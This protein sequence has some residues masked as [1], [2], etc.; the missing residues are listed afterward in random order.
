[1]E[2]RLAA[3]A[4]ASARIFRAGT[5]DETLK[6]ITEEARRIV[7]AHQCVTSLTDG[8]DWAQSVVAVSLSDKYAAWRNYEAK[9]DGA[10]IYSKV[11]RENRTMRLTQAELEAHPA[12]R[13]FGAEKDKHP[14]LRGWLAAP[15]VARDGT[16]LGLIQLSDKYDGEFDAA[17]E[18]AVVQLA[19]HAALA[20][21][22]LRLLAKAQAAER[23]FQE[24]AE[25]A[26]DWF[27]ETDAEH[28]FTYFG[29]TLGPLD[30]RLGL[31]RW[32]T[33][34]ADLAEAKW[35][36]HLA[37]LAARRAFR[38]FEYT[39]IDAAG[40]LH[41]LSVSGN[42]VFAAG[43]A[44]TGY[45]GTARDITGPREIE[46]KALAAADR[47]RQIV[48]TTNEGVWIV[49]ADVRTVFVNR[50]M[51]EMLGYAAEEIL[52]RQVY[53]FRP[54]EDRAN[55]EN[56]WAKRQQGVAEHREARFVRRDG[57][58]F[59]AQISAQP[60]TDSAGAFAGSLGMVTDISARKEAEAARMAS[61][62]RFRDFAE[63]GTDWLW[64]SDADH[65][66]T[67]MDGPPIRARDFA[68]G[69][70]RWEYGGVDPESPEWRRHRSDL[71]LHKPFRNFEYTV[72]AADGT[73][74]HFSVSGK[75]LF[76]RDGLFAGYRGAT[77]DSTAQYAA[78]TQARAS[79]KRF[80]DFA[81]VASDWMWETDSEHRFSYFSPSR[82][83]SQI[84]PSS[85]AL[86]RTRWQY[87]GADPAE[88]A[89][90][91]HLADLEARR[92]IQR[93]EYRYRRPGGATG[94][95]LVNGKP[96]F[97]EDG[98]FAGYRGT[99]T[100]VTA[101][102][103]AEA[104]AR[105]ANEQFR[106]VVETANEGMWITD[107]DGNI[108]F[109]NN[110][111]A[112]MLGYEREELVGRSI[113]DFVPADRVADVRRHWSERRASK[114]DRF[115]ARHRRKDGSEI[116][117]LISVA[118]RTDASGAFAGSITMFVDITD[119][120]RAEAAAAASEQR[121]KD[122]AEV[123]SD[124]LWETDADHR[125][126][127]I[128]GSAL[129]L[130]NRP[131]GRTR[132]DLAGATADDPP[133]RAHVADLDAHRAFRD[134]AFTV[135]GDGG[136]THHLVASGR[137]QFDG[138]GR[139]Q[140]YRGT[141]T[142]R[143]R[144]HEAEA[145]ALE[146]ERNFRRIV[147]TADEGIWMLDAARKTSYVNPRMAEM[148]GY[149]ADEMLG[150]F[151][152]EFLAPEDRAEA[153]AN[154]DKRRQNRV[155]KREWR[156]VRKDGTLV[157]TL[158]TSNTMDDQSGGAPG[159]LGMITDITELK[160]AEEA[161]LSAKR[162]MEALLASVSDG[163]VAIDNEW[164]FTYVNPAAERIL[165]A[166]AA[167]VIGRTSI[168]ALGIKS[169]NVFNACYAAAKRDGEP[170]SFTAYSEAFGRWLEVR[171]HPH[172]GGITLFF[173]DVTA[174]RQAH[175]ALAETERNLR[176]ALENNESILGSVSDGFAAFDDQWRFTHM[177]AAAERIW[178]MAGKDLIGRS[179]FDVM[180]IDDANPFHAAYID[181][182]KSGAPTAF[183]AY[184]QILGKWIE[185]HGFPH[186]GG[187][188]QFFRDVGDERRA[189]RTLVKNQRKL[190]AAREMN[191]RIFESSLDLF[192]ITDRNGNIVQ[193]NPGACDQSGYPM[194][195]LVGHVASE[196]CHPDDIEVTRAAMR[197]SRASHTSHTFEN[198]WL[199]KDGTAVHM[200]WS[201][202][203][204]EAEQKYF[205]IG[206][207][208]TERMQAQERLNRSQRLEAIGQLTGGIAHDFNNLLTVI[209]G[210]AEM[211]ARALKERDN[212][213]RMAELSLEAARRA[214][215]LTSQLLSFARRQTLAPNAIDANK[216]IED[217]KELL[218]RTLG[219]NIEIVLE[220][221]PAVW[222][223]RADS[224]QLESALVNLAV[225]ARDAMPNGGCLTFA[226]DNRTVPAGSAGAT[227]EL[228]P[229]DYVVIEVEDTGEGMTPSVLARVFEP[230]FTTKDVGK[231]SGLGLPMVYGFIKQ[232]GGHVAIDSVP[233]RGT[234]V[235]L[236]LPRS[237]EALA[238]R[239]NVVADAP[240]PGGNETVLV[241]EDDPAVRELVTAQLGR[242]GY[243]VLIAGNGATAR[244]FL[245]TGETVDL[246]FTDIMMPGGVSGLDLAGEAMTKLPGIK[247]LFTSGYADMPSHDPALGQV[248]L[249]RKPYKLRELAQSVRHALDPG[250]PV[251]V[252]AVPA[253]ASAGTPPG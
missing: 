190:D 244:N 47:Y 178:N 141:T 41:H 9:A 36:G 81:E 236:Y 124:W 106:H 14:P 56:R 220:R 32:E 174:V 73:I 23:R 38:N 156:Y 135:E 246:L 108:V 210:N 207:D 250:A 201:V 150:R 8:A 142:N 80:K 79:E 131:I 33:A 29:G 188:A 48:E 179:V 167:L 154:S 137:P 82:D 164:R 90:Q 74:R 62:E 117:V 57:T 234:K 87:A 132:W 231:G 177:N 202:A 172:P 251:A 160:R 151:H 230:F 209:M 208:L 148:L 84:D 60:L 77:R 184:S 43:G 173:R 248:E 4:D 166:P 205:L 157:W 111:I 11:C 253:V 69:K 65:R 101:Q 6:L 15:L 110:R 129:P 99:A 153:Q 204:S 165:G 152:W 168:D 5:L 140:G 243:R 206:R 249:L 103:A 25:I 143:T 215:E 10:G 128:S 247:V 126:T 227:S 199:R 76:E 26:S 102:R 218:Q 127:Y 232:S 92:P 28:R 61:E 200:N 122:F 109:A 119:R 66:I 40:R 134:F 55:R 239:P 192:C 214:A 86:G 222:R 64:E 16:N 71:D 221:A 13:R 12:W 145:A 139:F 223:C 83:H 113:V 180:K 245:F 219:A 158:V 49:D 24:F 189:H 19:S 100:D 241:V 217:A 171:A 34:E 85:D 182:K 225:N 97:A 52:G 17:D 162:E 1:M 193:V 58:I 216:L 183:T 198:R 96:F 187:Y 125:L 238:P 240:L 115:E 237:V 46:A 120:K 70:R 78:E 242:L 224:T 118:P 105:E 50:R 75:P 212:L 159:V 181:S 123:A 53:D 176:A 252:P 114:V 88:P 42:P 94:V 146:N 72:C 18:A 51:C 194:N 22:N 161:A 20:L 213:R 44:F 21:E 196:F 27:W 229:G 37:D 191:Q 89:W 170:V 149:S 63:V 169:D 91:S 130:D 155:E 226:T 203:W 163:F 138:D 235:S 59:W 45:R 68:I 147:E 116:W 2:R 112:E 197:D 121:F 7:G 195:E 39:R 93:F 31:T 35:Q 136:R 175:L 107:R 3:L 95:S 104:A 67:F 30:R 185:V 144:Q 228:L 186:A 54:P 133:W 233:G 98:A 211:L